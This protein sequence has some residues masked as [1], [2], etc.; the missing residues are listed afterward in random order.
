[1][2]SHGNICSVAQPLTLDTPS[3]GMGSF[4]QSL[5][6]PCTAAPGTREVAG[7]WVDG[8]VGGQRGE[9]T[10]AHMDEWV[11]DWVDEWM[12]RWMDKICLEGSTGPFFFPSK[13]QAT[14]SYLN[15]HLSFN[16]NHNITVQ[17]SN[18]ELQPQT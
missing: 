7:G 16:S 15:N 3:L 2:S 14:W 9:W 8:W 5:L 1:M 11:T 6:T 18:S 4:H 13:P 17:F 10:D 12:D